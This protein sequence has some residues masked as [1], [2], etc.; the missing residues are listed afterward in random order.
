MQCFCE[1]DVE[2]FITVVNYDYKCFDF[3]KKNERF[4]CFHL[5]KSLFRN[6]TPFSFGIGLL[7]NCRT[8]CNQNLPSQFSTSKLTTDK[9]KTSFH[10]ISLMFLLIKL[11]FVHFG[12]YLLIASVD[13]RTAYIIRKPFVCI[14]FSEVIV[15]VLTSSF[16]KSSLT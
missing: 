12:R 4:S 16:E 11:L 7:E 10:R 5:P 3:I 15:E 9:R 13:F 6:K 2:T 1:S 14:L 8:D